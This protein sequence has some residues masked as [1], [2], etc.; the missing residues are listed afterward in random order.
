MVVSTFFM[1]DKDR[2]GGFLEESFLLADMK[3]DILL[4]ILFPTMIN[5]DIDFQA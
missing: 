1:S 3:P 2:R 5:A 4:W